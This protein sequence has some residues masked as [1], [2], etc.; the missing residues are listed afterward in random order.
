MVCR[1]KTSGLATAPRKKNKRMGGRCRDEFGLDDLALLDLALLDLALLDLALL[2]LALLLELWS[3]Q[4]QACAAASALAASALAAAAA[5]ALDITG[6][7]HGGRVWTACSWIAAISAARMACL[8]SGH[9]GCWP[10]RDA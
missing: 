10:P 3:A 1:S 5:L 7:T 2:D 4:A 9:V 6:A 8:V